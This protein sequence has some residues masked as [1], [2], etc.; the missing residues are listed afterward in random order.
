MTTKELKERMDTKDFYLI[1]DTH[2]GHKVIQDFEP[3]R[4]TLLETLGIQEQR[5][6]TTA[7]HDEALIKLWNETIKPG[8]LVIHLGD[9][10]FAKPDRYTSRLNGDIVL[11]KGNHDR[12]SDVN[13]YKRCGFAKVIDG[14]EVLQNV[15]YGKYLPDNSRF[16]G[17]YWNGYL[18]THYALWSKD[19]YDNQR[20]DGDL[21]A[22]AKDELEEL[23]PWDSDSTFNIHGHLHSKLSDYAM[24]INVSAEA[25]GFKP[26]HYSELSKLYSLQRA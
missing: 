23:Y 26:I 14:F 22:E 1:S 4:N 16:T 17:L 18:L 21:I 11:V 24:A 2:F 10:S 6:I 19:E 5:V 12:S 7:E 15:P 25:I 3:T 9:F 20:E 8:D 13:R